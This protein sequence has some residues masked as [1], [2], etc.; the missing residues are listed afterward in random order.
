MSPLGAT[1]ATGLRTWPAPAAPAA[2]VGK[3]RSR[4]IKHGLREGGTPSSSGGK[5]GKGEKQ[6]LWQTKLAGQR[7]RRDRSRVRTS[8][9]PQTSLVASPDRNAFPTADLRLGHGG[10]AAASLRPVPQNSVS[11]LSVTGGRIVLVDGGRR[12]PILSSHL[13]S[14]F[15]PVGQGSEKTDQPL[16]PSRKPGPGTRPASR[17][18]HFEPIKLHLPPSASSIAIASRCSS[19]RYSISSHCYT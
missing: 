1:V 6:S 14:L 4:P 18:D 9:R 12:L 3:P 5:V 8:A 16:E 11:I 13:G 7:R 19:P 2:P 10:F 15:S 17:G